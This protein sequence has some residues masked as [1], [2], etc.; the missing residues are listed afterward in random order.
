M[1]EATD[2]NSTRYR[3][4]AVA[5]LTGISPDTLRIWERRYTAVSPQRSPRGGRLYSAGDVGRLRLL[6]QLLDV[7][8]AIGEIA[9]LDSGALRQRLEMACRLPSQIAS[10]P[11]SSC[12]VVVVGESLASVL[13]EAGDTLTWVTLVAAYRDIAGFEARGGNEGADVLVVEQTTLHVDSAMRVVD[14]LGRAKA[15]HAVVVYRYASREALAQLPA[16]TCSAICAPVD[17]PS[18]QAHCLAMLHPGRKVSAPATAES[19]GVVRPAPPRRYDDEALAQLASLSST[20]KCECPRHLV[21]LITSLSAFE[22]Y[23]TECESRNPRDAALHG[24]LHATTSQARHL[25]E[26]ALDQLLDMENI[27]I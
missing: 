23:S 15:A 6:K 16:S 7:G 8:D 17:P 26:A 20:V 1:N 11:T 24:Y 14:W 21:E 18:L 3:I 12:R 4:G 13:E 9:G 25:I 27:T 10:V 22:R 2:N 5:R 19:S